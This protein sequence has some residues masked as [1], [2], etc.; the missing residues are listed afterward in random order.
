MKEE[1]NLQ[2][3]LCKFIQLGTD[4]NYYAINDKFIWLRTIDPNCD[5]LG[6]NGNFI[7]YETIF[8]FLEKINAI[9]DSTKTVYGPFYKILHRNRICYINSCYYDIIEM[10]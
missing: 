4:D 9:I 8:L 5:F 2:G 1:K 3:A 10:K 6:D 7:A